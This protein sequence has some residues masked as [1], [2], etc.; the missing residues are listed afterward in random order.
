MQLRF[1]LVSGPKSRP[2][3]VEFGP[4]LNV[5]YGGS[6]TG[7]SHILRLIDYCLGASKPPDPIIEQAEYDLAHLGVALE[8][9]VAGRSSDTPH[10]GDDKYNEW[11]G[12][13]H[14]QNSAGIRAGVS[15]PAR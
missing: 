2:A 14:D 5:I 15:R 7:K 9:V 11:D 3:V 1:L 8:V 12:R 13:R 4:G 6:N 10:Q